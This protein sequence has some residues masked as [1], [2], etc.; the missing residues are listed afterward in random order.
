MDTF[1]TSYLPVSNSAASFVFIYVISVI[2]TF[3]TLLT[4]YNAS[5]YMEAFVRP[6]VVG[7]LYALA[8]AAS[9]AIF[10]TLAPLLSRFGNTVAAAAGDPLGTINFSRRGTS[11]GRGGMIHVELRGSG[12]ANGFGGDMVFSTKGNNVT[13]V[14]ERMRITHAGNVGIG[15]TAPG[16]R[17]DVHGGDIRIATG[18]QG[19]TFPDGTRQTTA[20]SGGGEIYIDGVRLVARL[21]NLGEDIYGPWNWGHTSDTCNGLVR[22]DYFCTVNERRTCTDVGWTDGEPYGGGVMSGSRHRTVTCRFRAVFSE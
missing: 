12:G 21:I 2:F 17:L 19:I 18:G 15:T 1:K 22:A 14:G 16:A 13:T 6:E 3:H 9:I 10:A 8:S 20:M 7:V 4:A 5:T 11:H